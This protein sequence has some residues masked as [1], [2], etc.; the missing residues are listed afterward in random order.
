MMP[1]CLNVAGEALCALIIISDPMIRGMVYDSI[2][3]DVELEIFVCQ[4]DYMEAEIFHDCPRDI[5]ILTIEDYQQA[6]G[7]LLTGTA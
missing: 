5:L 6:G 7:R 1:V 3:E 2:E 4:S